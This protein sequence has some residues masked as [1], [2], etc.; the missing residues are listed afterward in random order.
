[1]DSFTLMM[2]LVVRGLI[3]IFKQGVCVCS[4][5]IAKMMSVLGFRRQ[6]GLGVC[7]HVEYCAALLTCRR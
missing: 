5:E 2:T 4:L 6:S 7:L 3:L 1:M